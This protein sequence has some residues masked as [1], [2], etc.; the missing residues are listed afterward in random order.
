M[1]VLQSVA[2]HRPASLRAAV[3]QDGHF[4]LSCC[5]TGSNSSMDEEKAKNAAPLMEFRIG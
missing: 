5:G 3:V 1:R 4:A 2:K